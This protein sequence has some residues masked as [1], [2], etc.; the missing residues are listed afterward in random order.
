MVA[1][2]LTNSRQP[3]D[4]LWEGSTIDSNSPACGVHAELGCKPALAGLKPRLTKTS[5]VQ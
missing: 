3:D 1:G 5:D 4:S 2:E